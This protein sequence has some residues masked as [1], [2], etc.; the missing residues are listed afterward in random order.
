MLLG[1][2]TPVLHPC[3]G[4]QRHLRAESSRCPFCGL[5]V[6]APERV[7]HRT[8]PRG[9]ALVAGSAL[10][11]GACE[12][13]VLATAHAQTR[14]L[15]PASLS[16]QYAAP[17]RFFNTQDSGTPPRPTADAGVGDGAGDSVGD[18]GAG[19]RREPDGAAQPPRR[20][21]GS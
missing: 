2:M 4:C 16:A 8:S 19:P 6:G 5:A 13:V 17:P 1:V 12:R 9:M 15:E 7:A 14:D 20:R 21:W 11:L 18:Q 3:E 10:A